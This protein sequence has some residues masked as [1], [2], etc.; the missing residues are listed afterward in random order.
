MFQLKMQISCTSI[1]EMFCCSIAGASTLVVALHASF[2]NI[3]AIVT[4]EMDAFL[5]DTETV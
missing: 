2:Y 4:E 5:A 1:D 3:D